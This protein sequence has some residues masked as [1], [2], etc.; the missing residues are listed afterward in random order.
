MINHEVQEDR[1]TFVITFPEGHERLHGSAYRNGPEGSTWTALVFRPEILVSISGGK[2]YHPP[3]TGM[4]T[5]S[6][7]LSSKEEAVQA[8]LDYVAREDLL[9]SKHEDVKLRLKRAKDQVEMPAQGPRHANEWPVN[10]R[11][12]LRAAA[13]VARLVA[14]ADENIATLPEPPDFYSPDE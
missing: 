10:A 11:A 12:A 4:V 3:G 2:E 7:K 5:V 6:D 14:V 9:A 8:V 13:E 1:V